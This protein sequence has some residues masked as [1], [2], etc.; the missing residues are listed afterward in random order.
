VQTPRVFQPI[1]NVPRKLRAKQRTKHRAKHRKPCVN[2][3][4][5]NVYFA[6]KA[7]SSQFVK[8]CSVFEGK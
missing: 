4:F 2:P 1:I 3:T 6:S 7:P 8:C 5:P